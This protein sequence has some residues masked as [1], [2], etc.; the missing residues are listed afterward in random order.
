MLALVESSEHLQSKYGNSA[1]EQ[2]CSELL[3]ARVAEGR[4]FKLDRVSSEQVR[5][6]I[7]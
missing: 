6:E 5:G 2:I 4:N 3:K 1:L 7:A